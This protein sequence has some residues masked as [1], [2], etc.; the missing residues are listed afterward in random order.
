MRSFPLLLHAALVLSTGAASAAPLSQHL[1][2]KTP[3]SRIAATC[4]DGRRIP[5]EQHLIFGIK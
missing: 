4:L 1:P 5:T 2:S 3:A